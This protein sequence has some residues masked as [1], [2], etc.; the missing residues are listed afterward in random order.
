MKVEIDINVVCPSCGCVMTRF[1]DYVAC[2]SRPCEHYGRKFEKPVIT[3]KEYKDN[4]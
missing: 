4:E 3:L 1:G 2:C